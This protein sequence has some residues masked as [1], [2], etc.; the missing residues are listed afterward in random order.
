MGGSLGERE[1]DVGTG[2]RMESVSTQ[3]QVLPNFNKMFSFIK[4][5]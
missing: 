1:I 2:A 4:Y 3:F 5:I